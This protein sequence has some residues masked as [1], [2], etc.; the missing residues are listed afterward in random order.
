MVKNDEI[1]RDG[2]AAFKYILVDALFP[3]DC[4]G[5]WRCPIEEAADQEHCDD[6][7]L[8]R[9]RRRVRIFGREILRKSGDPFISV[10]VGL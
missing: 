3:F 9:R 5:K 8:H 2:I 6:E 4:D 1:P 10:I 7:D